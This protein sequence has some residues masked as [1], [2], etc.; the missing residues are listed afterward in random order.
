VTAVNAVGEG[1]RSAAIVLTPPGVPPTI[2]GF[3]PAIAVGGT[4]IAI[5]GSGIGGCGTTVTFDTRPAGSISGG[6]GQVIATSPASGGSGR[7]TV[8]TAAGTA[9]MATD[10]YAVPAGMTVAEIAVTDRMAVGSARAVPIGGSGKAG[11]VLFSGQAG[12]RISLRM[13]STITSTDVTVQN[14]DGSTLASASGVGTGGAFIDTRTLAADGT[15][16]I[17]V[18]PRS[19]YTGT[20]TLTLY[21]VPPDVAAAI[22]PGGAAVPLAIATPGQNGSL[23]FSGQAGQA[24][25]LVISAVTVSQTD[26]SVRRPDGTNLVNPTL[27]TTSGRT[28]AFT[29]NVA[30]SYTIVVNPRTTH[31]GSLTFRL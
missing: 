17:V 7:I 5:D 18:N 4:A 1:P 30:G 22:T 8:A 15:Y 16:T 24:Y 2:T 13:T 6:T 29:A 14:P 27:V 26:V 10:F 23:T 25:S 20:M 19:S 31:T 11:L 21:D 9:S 12:D 28:I 3:S